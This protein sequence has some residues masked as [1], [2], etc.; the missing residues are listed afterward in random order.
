[1]TAPL[2]GGVVRTDRHTTAYFE[3]GPVDGTPIVFVHGWPEFSYAWRRQLA[4]FAAR[5]YRAIA[6]DLRGVGGSSRYDTYDAYAQREI[7]RDLIE[8]ADALG[9]E[10]AIWVGHDWGAAA[11]WHLARYAPERCRAVAGLCV[12]YASLDLGL[13]HLTTLVN[14]EIYPASRYPC[15]QFEYIAF[16]HERF[17]DARVAFEANLE[18][19]FK[20]LMRGADPAKAG[21]PFSTAAVRQQGGWFRGGAAPNLPLDERILSPADLEAYV[22]AYTKTGFFGIDALYMNDDDNLRFA[23]QSAPELTMPVLF[24]SGTYDYVCDTERSD[25]MV[26]MR[27]TCRDLT[28]VSLETSHWMMHEK[29]TDVETALVAWIDASSAA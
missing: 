8:L 21:Q 7:V 19:T 13:T 23:S 29:P 17:D 5:G 6:P 16:Y 11:L 22:R 1:M 12:P 3:A 26:P 28:I 18:A 20:V 25:L 10:R 14:R 2:R 15:G 9:I 4:A 24:L 27:G